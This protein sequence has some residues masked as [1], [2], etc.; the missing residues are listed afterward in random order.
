ME[1]SWSL[2][3]LGLELYGLLRL[4]FL[5]LGLLFVTESFDHE[6][7]HVLLDSD[8]VLF[9]KGQLELEKVIIYH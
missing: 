8:L 2:G 3:V 4:L 1:L 6:G 9:V 7:G 5:L